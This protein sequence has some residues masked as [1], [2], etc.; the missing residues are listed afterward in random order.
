MS[1]RKYR[2][3]RKTPT[4]HFDY[5]AGEQPVE[6]REYAEEAEQAARVA[7]R[8]RGERRYAVLCVA[9]AAALLIAALVGLR[10]AI[11][12]DGPGAQA[13]SRTRAAVRMEASGYACPVDFE[14][15]WDRNE[16]V[17]GWLS[18]PQLG[19]EQ[20]ILMGR[21]N[22]EYLRTALDGEHDA[23]GSIFL[24]Y[25]CDPQMRGYHTVIYGHNTRDGEMFSNLELFKDAGAFAELR[26]DIT[27]WLPDRAV[28]LRV[29]AAQ[30]APSRPDRRQV[31]FPSR[32]AFLDYALPVLEA[33][34]VRELPDG[35]LSALFSLI[36][37]SY[38]GEDYRTY[39]YAVEID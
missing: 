35:E 6:L 25:A 24:D 28:H 9:A 39:V 21:D 7:L 37:C 30:A 20:P 16:D 33:C 5:S 10:Y 17:I 18:A 15:L 19:I 1:A 23:H 27:I 14:A 32:E 11:L 31:D 22:D 36:T 34:E 29:V 4:F 3:R 2:P 38:E 8:K 26:D 12:S 13:A